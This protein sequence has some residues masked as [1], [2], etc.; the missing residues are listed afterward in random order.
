MQYRSLVLVAAA[1]LL[2]SC[3]V[4][5]VAFADPGDSAACG[6]FSA[7]D[8]TMVAPGSSFKV[9]ANL[10]KTG[11]SVWDA[12]QVGVMMTGS[13]ANQW[14]VSSIKRTP[15]TYPSS[16]HGSIT[17]V[18]VAK[19]PTAA[20]V[21]PLQVS[22]ARNGVPFGQPCAAHVVVNTMSA[23][24]FSL[25]ETVDRSTA[26]PGDTVT[27]TV[28]LTNASNAPLVSLLDDQ[29]PASL[30]F[31]SASDAPR[32]PLAGKDALTGRTYQEYFWPLMIIGAHTS[33]QVTIQATVN[34]NV[35]PQ[36]VITNPVSGYYDAAVWHADAAVSLTV[37][38]P[39]PILTLTQASMPSRDIAVRNQP[40][41]DLLRFTAA[42]DSAGDVLLTKAVFRAASGSLATI[43]HYSLWADTDGNGSVDTA[44]QQGVVSQNG[45]V[46]FTGLSNGGYLVPRNTNVLLE[47]HGDVAS[48]LV[49]H[50]LTLQFATTASGYVAAQD[51]AT[52]NALSGIQTD[53]AC[54]AAPCHI[55]V[56]TGPATAWQLVDQ[57]DL[58]VTLDTTPVALHQLLGGTL[59]DTILRLEFH[60]ENEPVDVTKLQLTF[61]SAVQSVDYLELWRPGESSPFASAS[62]GLC[63]SDSVPAFT[64]CAL[65]QS[66]QLVVPKGGDVVVLARPSM[67]DDVGGAV[68]GESIRL[69]VNG[70]PVVDEATGSGAV[71]ARG[72]VSMNFLHGNNG[73]TAGNEGEIFIGTAVPG[74]NATILGNQ[75]VS[76]LSKI[77]SIANAGTDPD[78][79]PVPAG[80][81]DIGHFAVTAAPNANSKNGLNKVT[82]SGVI[83]N[84]VATNVAFDGT[85]FK[86]YNWVNST[87]AKS[88]VPMT[89]AGAVITGTASGSFVVACTGLVS[90]TAP[91]NPSVTIDQ[92]TSQTFV[93][94]ANVTNA[95]L[96]GNATSTLQVSLQS[97]AS[98]LAAAFGP[99]ASHF[100]WIDQ[101][102][103][104]ATTH[105]FLWAEYTDTVV[106][107]TAYQG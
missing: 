39:S 7:T 16:F 25:G 44:V 15:V 47:L 53:G 88:C 22:M 33:R 105:S 52:G 51:N 57:G 3:C 62:A 23:S 89:T 49:S 83:F 32:P 48:A 61:G 17:V 106:K 58:Y 91:N 94:H 78:G 72:V 104:L 8:T 96:S 75:N 99:A 103:G 55:H 10:V 38:R 42:A 24:N 101:D 95:H 82:L 65:M 107:S 41:I 2:L 64:L 85:A 37:V 68:S 81:A 31:V 79:T 76:V 56:T 71:H 80:V 12:T 77:A 63:G 86:F 67:K 40:D 60:A 92:G 87:V 102:T 29:L 20:G 19:A 46:T 35:P 59:G 45:L 98:P 27:Y 14:G 90:A 50:T 34:A 30:T 54:A 1:G 73:N 28:T 9:T 100:Q 43:Q 5:S 36:T 26:S 84:V 97:F 21:Y 69:S 70:S 66:H 4:P 11:D 74:A 18:F 13:G 6:A 93:L